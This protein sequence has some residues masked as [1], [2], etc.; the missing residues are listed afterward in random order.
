MKILSEK[1]Q[2][3]NKLNEID[4]SINF[5]NIEY[6]TAKN[7]LTRKI[8]WGIFSF[9]PIGYDVL[10]YNKNSLKATLEFLVEYQNLIQIALSNLETR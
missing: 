5:I 8:N 4:K 9:I 1:E 7:K 2:L 6:T 3:Y 10:A